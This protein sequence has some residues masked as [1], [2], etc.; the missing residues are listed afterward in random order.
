MTEEEAQDRSD[1]DGDEYELREEE[2]RVNQM[3]SYFDNYQPE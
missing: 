3:N 1:Q 2:D